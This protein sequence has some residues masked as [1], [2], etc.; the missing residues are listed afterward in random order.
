MHFVS[1]FDLA[2]KCQPATL[3]QYL[4]NDLQGVTTVH[5]TE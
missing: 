5:S 4:H 1:D 3:P 2:P